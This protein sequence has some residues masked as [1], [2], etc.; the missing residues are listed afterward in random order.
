MRTR[1]ALQFLSLDSDGGD[2]ASSLRH[3]VEKGGVFYDAYR[4]YSTSFF[5]SFGAAYDHLRKVRQA[6]LRDGV[7]R[8]KC[9]D[10]D[11]KVCPID[12]DKPDGFHARAA[13]DGFDASHKSWAQFVGGGLYDKRG[14][15]LSHL[16]HELVGNQVAYHYLQYANTTLL[17]LLRSQTITTDIAALVARSAKARNVKSPLPHAAICTGPLCDK[18]LSRPKCAYSSLPKHAA[19][20]VGDLVS[21]ASFVTRW[22]NVAVGGGKHDASCGDLDRAAACGDETSLEC[23][24]HEMACS[25]GGQTRAFEGFA[26]SGPLQ[27]DIDFSRAARCA[28]LI[29]EPTTTGPR[30]ITTANWKTELKV[31]V[32]GAPCGPPACVAVGGD[33]DPTQSLYIDLAK[34]PDCDECKTCWMLQPVHVDLEVSPLP[35]LGADVCALRDGACAAAGDWAHYDLGCTPRPNRKDACW[36]PLLRNV[37]SGELS[38]VRNPQMVRALVNSIVVL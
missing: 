1:P 9:K 18:H 30:P 14:K 6:K 17:R 11:V 32:E 26:G 4:R 5:S 21:N 3:A 28:V 31:T 36:R 20:D 24:S 34:V 22:S 7:S 29:S 33:G 19:P 27:L 2:N 8:D 12:A 13:Y 38:D 35:E 16:G 15:Y 10:K 23:F 25:H 37:Y